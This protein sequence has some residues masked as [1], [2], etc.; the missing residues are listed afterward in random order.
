V[1]RS[2]PGTSSDVE[3]L[4]GTAPPITLSS[5]SSTAWLSEDD[6]NWHAFHDVPI[7]GLVDEESEEE[8]F[9][10]LPPPPKC[11]KKNYDLTRRFQMEWAATCPWSEM[12]LTNEGL[13]HMVKCSICSAVRGRALIIGPKFDTVNR[14]TKRIGHLKNT[15][16]YAVRRPTTVLQQIQG[17]SSLESR[18]K[19]CL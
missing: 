1:A 6:P 9:P 8:D 7:R 3:I 10:E 16:L 13:L 17:C 12:I 15:E 11:T 2:T 4:A 14:H 19:V 18:K 5:D